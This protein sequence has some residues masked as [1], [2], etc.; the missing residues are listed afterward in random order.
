MVARDFHR[1]FIRVFDIPFFDPKEQPT[2]RAFFHKHRHNGFSLV[3]DAMNFF[4]ILLDPRGLSFT[5]QVS[6]FTSKEFPVLEPET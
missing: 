5:F 6:S 1:I 4:N 3:T 2:F